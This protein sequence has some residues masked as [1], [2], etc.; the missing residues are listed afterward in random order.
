M[1]LAAFLCGNTYL[2]KLK[3]TLIVSNKMLKYGCVLL[4]H[5]TLQIAVSQEWMNELSWFFTCSSMVLG[6]LKVTLGMHMVKYGC[7]LLGLGTL[8]SALSKP[9][10]NQ[11]I[12]LIS[13]TLGDDGIIFS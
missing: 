7:D 13:C 9:K 12:E 6:K 8:K 4:G 11:W 10:I 2:R 5:R 1:N 3:V